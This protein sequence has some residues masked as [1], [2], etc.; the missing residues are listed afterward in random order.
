LLAQI[1]RGKLRGVEAAI[2]ARAEEQLKRMPPDDVA[3]AE[4]LVRLYI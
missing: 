2:L 4:E 1:K 3:T